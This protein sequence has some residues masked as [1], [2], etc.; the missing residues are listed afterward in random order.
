MGDQRWQTT[1]AQ[2]HVYKPTAAVEEVVV[3]ANATW[4][5]CSHI[6]FVFVGVFF[7]FTSSPN[8]ATTFHLSL[9]PQ[10]DP[11]SSRRPYQSFLI[12]HPSI[13]RLSHPPIF[14]LLGGP[15]TGQSFLIA[16]MLSMCFSKDNFFRSFQINEK[17]LLFRSV[18]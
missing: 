1:C 9:S 3:T 17:S 14:T 13:H 5:Y 16:I 6:F 11:N 2:T 4:P 8:K 12:R 7:S 15:F 18:G 10:N